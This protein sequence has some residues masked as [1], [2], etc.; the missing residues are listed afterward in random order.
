MRGKSLT[1]IRQQLTIYSTVFQ[2]AAAVVFKR[3]RVQFILLAAI[4]ATGAGAYIVDAAQASSGENIRNA[5]TASPGVTAPDKSSSVVS[6][7]NQT[8]A[9]KPDVPST[10]NDTSTDSAA[11]VTTNVNVSNNA[12]AGSQANVSIN[13]Q[14]MTL[15]PNGSVSKNIVTPGGHTH[16]SASVNSDDSNGSV[17][18]H[19]SSTSESNSSQDSP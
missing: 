17:S 16:V 2:N 10:V 5:A 15:P 6:S 8:E 12:A 7:N 13:G 19:V 4:V 14:N 3:R 1:Q 9:G 18:V 11:S